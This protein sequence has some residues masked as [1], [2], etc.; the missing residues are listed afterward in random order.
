MKGRLADSVV[1]SELKN[2]IEREAVELFSKPL[3]KPALPKKVVQQPREEPKPRME[4]YSESVDGEHWQEAED[5]LR[6]IAYKKE[7]AKKDD[8]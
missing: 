5:E 7:L 2:S 3:D 8:V 1:T 4:H 6:P